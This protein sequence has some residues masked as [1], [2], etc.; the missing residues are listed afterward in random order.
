M[1]AVSEGC[2]NGLLPY[3]EGII[4]ML[5]PKLAD[6]RPMVGGARPGRG[7]Q[8]RSAAWAVLG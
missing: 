1:G 5:L 2:H 4:S 3:L 7:E 8:P 6:P